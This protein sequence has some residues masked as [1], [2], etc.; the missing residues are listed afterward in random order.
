MELRKK[1]VEVLQAKGH[2]GR[3]LIDSYSVVRANIRRRVIEIYPDHNLY[4]LTNAEDI[5]AALSS[6]GLRC[7]YRYSRGEPSEGRYAAGSGIE[8]IVIPL[9]QSTGPFGDLS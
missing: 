8:E 4:F 3:L 6:A 7:R 1:V 5:L 9:D 2:D